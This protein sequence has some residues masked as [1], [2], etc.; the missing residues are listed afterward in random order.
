MEQK[1][2]ILI[3]EDALFNHDLYR[4]AFE[5]FGF[6]VKILENADGPF[7][8]T[9]LEF[10]PHII[11]MD[12]MMGKDGVPTQYD[13]F[14]A[15]QLLKGDARTTGIPVFILTNFFEESK[16]MRAKELGAADFINLAGQGMPK[17][18]E[19]FFHYLADPE[20]YEPVHPYF[21]S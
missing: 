14:D 6:E 1:P 18:P 10:A 9:V 19:Y 11:S 2:K 13:G 4:D 20:H 8:E 16:V 7:I 3:V 5:Q 17:I 12:I 21:Q 15:L